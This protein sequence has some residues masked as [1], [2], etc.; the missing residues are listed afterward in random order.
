[1]CLQS[2]TGGVYT[3]SE[4]GT[5]IDH[6]VLVVGFGTDESSGVEY[7]IVKNSWGA[8]WGDKGY[9]YLAATSCAITR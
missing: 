1:M 5:A 7:F 4:C 6:A 2:Y 8:A 9:M 3:S